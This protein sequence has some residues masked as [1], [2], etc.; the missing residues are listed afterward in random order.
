MSRS[1]ET[2]FCRDMRFRPV[3]SMAEVLLTAAEAARS[4]GITVTTLYDWL[5]QS[6]RGLLVIRGQSATIDYFQGGPRGQ[7]RIRIESSEVD[8]VRELMRVHPAPLRTRRPP[9][10]RVSYPGITVPL[11][12]PE[13]YR[14]DD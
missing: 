4:L 12:R 5:G 1:A 10:R 13:D 9:V 11:G 8:R 6:D 7:G 3:E 14:P 2:G